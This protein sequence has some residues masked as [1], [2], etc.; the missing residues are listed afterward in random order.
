VS[1]QSEH[2]PEFRHLQ[3]G[4]VGSTNVEAL[5]RAEQGEASGLWITADRQ[6]QGRGRRGRVWTSE[7]GNLYASLLLIDP[8]DPARLGSLP[9]AVSTA[10]HDALAAVLPDRSGLNIKWPNDVLIDG[11]K[12]SGI[13]LESSILADGRRA[14][15]IGC[16]INVAHH[17]ADGFYSSTCLREQGA[18]VSPQELFARL[19]VSM[20]E[21][22]A[23]WD[24]G[25]GIAATR[26]SWLERAT[27][28]GEAIVVRLPDQEIHGL[29]EGVDAEGRLILAM[30]DGKTQ[31]IAAGDVFFSAPA[32]T[33]RNCNDR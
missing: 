33:D 21:A 8:G 4:D 32:R 23:Q 9:L 7:P 18:T 11:A 24:G 20:Q 3:L 25:K 10:V 6:L 26:A 12:T 22:L 19:F 2:Y 13:L 1:K 27:G 30:S 16:G 5:V 17:P 14:V 31:T 29:F 28:V 15:V